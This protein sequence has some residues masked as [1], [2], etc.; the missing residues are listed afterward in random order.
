MKKGSIEIAMAKLRGMRLRLKILMSGGVCGPGLR[1][2][3]GV[4]FKYPLCGNIAFGKN[5]ELGSNIEFHVDN[6][7]RL[8]IGSN[9]KITGYCFIS[10]VQQVEIHENCLI[11]EFVSIRD[12]D[13]GTKS[14]ILMSAQPLT[15]SSINIGSDTWLARGA[16]ILKGVSLGTG[17]VVGANAVV[18]RSFGD[19]SVLV[20][21]P[22]KMVKRRK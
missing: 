20:G 10:C 17:C 19:E 9:T 14:G 21:V 3:P 1:V 7:A 12:A 11:A 18:T 22:A 5:I 15:A 2:G 6:D 16:C 13:H 8:K 4:T